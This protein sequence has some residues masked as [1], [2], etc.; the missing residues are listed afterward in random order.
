MDSSN[1]GAAGGGDEAYWNHQ[2]KLEEI[3]CVDRVTEAEQRNNAKK[4]LRIILSSAQPKADDAMVNNASGSGGGGGHGGAGGVTM[5][6]FAGMTSRGSPY[7]GA[8]SSS[9]APPSL[10]KDQMK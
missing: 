3:A 5:A 2:K 4:K 10:H 8:Q 6:M 7:S 9:S 1:A